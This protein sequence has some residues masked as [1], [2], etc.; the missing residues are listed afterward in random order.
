MDP[1]T[2]FQVAID[3][4]VD[5]QHPASYSTGIS[6]Q[7]RATFSGGGIREMTSSLRNAG[8][9]LCGEEPRQDRARWRLALGQIR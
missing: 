5:I 7:S 1:V 6:Q 3:S 2:N 4:N 9:K 8:T